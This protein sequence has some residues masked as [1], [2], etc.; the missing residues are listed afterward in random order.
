MTLHLDRDAWLARLIDEHGLIFADCVRA[1]SERQT[2]VAAEYIELARERWHDEGT[3]EIDDWTIVS[4]CDGASGDYV[5][6]WVWVDSPEA[7]K[8]TCDC[9]PDAVAS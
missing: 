9:D 5:L 7:G 8:H 1:F 4:G 2:E 3:V 6:A